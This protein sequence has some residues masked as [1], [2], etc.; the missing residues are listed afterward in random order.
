[1]VVIETDIVAD[2]MRAEPNAEVLA[3]MDDR[4]A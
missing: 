1:M 3:W 4:S 2:L